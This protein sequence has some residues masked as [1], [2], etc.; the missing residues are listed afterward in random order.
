VRSSERTVIGKGGHV[1]NGSAPTSR[2]R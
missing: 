1:R 2:R